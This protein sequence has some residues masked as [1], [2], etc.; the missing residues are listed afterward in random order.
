MEDIS[1]TKSVEQLLVISRKLA[2]TIQEQFE[3]SG[4]CFECKQHEHRYNCY[5]AVILG[6]N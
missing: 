6:L 1:D 2:D 4:Y 5:V 3:E